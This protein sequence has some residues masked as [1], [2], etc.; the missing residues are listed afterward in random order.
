MADPTEASIR[1]T[2]Q[3]EDTTVLKSGHITQ[4]I[5]DAKLDTGQSD[6]MALRYYTCYL[7]ALTWDALSPAER[8]ENVKIGRPRP[9]GFLKAYENRI[10]ALRLS[11]S[12]SNIGIRKT[13]INKDF[14]YD[15]TD[16]NIRPRRDSD[17]NY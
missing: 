17:P 6:E 14:F 10:S 8:I 2:L 1:L 7:I 15:T 16:N 4:A 11:S 3:I 12:T 13:S 9:E 5:S